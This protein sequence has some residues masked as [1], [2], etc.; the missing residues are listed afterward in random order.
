MEAGRNT[1]GS[2]EAAVR[3]PPA[4]VGPRTLFDLGAIDLS[5]RV[6]S[7]TDLERFNPHRGEMA[8]LDWIV[9]HNHN[10]SQAVGLKHVRR[11][12]FWVPGHFPQR[13]M[14]P[15]VLMIEA[16]AQLACFAF[17]ARR[18]GSQVVAFLRIKDAAFRGMVTPGDDLYLLVNEIKCGRRQFESDI[19]GVVGD[20]IAF[21]A[22]ISGMTMNP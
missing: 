22:R 7:R 9:W 2:A 5:A 18:P 21:D 10:Y 6:Y 15:G 20:R 14:L 13:P 12:E 16:G 4:T 3:T 19:Q 8:L 11:D 1:G 17:N